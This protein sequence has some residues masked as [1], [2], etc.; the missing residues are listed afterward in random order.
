MVKTGKGKKIVAV[1][2]YGS[3]GRALALNF[4]DSG[5]A[6]VIGLPPRSRSRRMA[7]ADGFAPILRPGV[8]AAEAETVCLALPDHLHGQAYEREI[9]G[10]L[11]PG[12]TLLFLH[13]LSVHFG[14][15]SPPP[16]CNVILIAPHAPGVAVREKYLE[17]S[18]IHI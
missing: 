1:L 2:G 9:A 18:L 13:G 6:V 12:S 8:A 14:L 7:R 15:V 5:Y 4:R 17:L 11:R 10:R 3:Q 16:D